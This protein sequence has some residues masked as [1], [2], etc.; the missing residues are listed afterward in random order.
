MR[1]SDFRFWILRIGHTIFNIQFAAIVKTR[2]LRPP[3]SGQIEIHHHLCVTGLQETCKSHALPEQADRVLDLLAP[4]C[5]CEQ[6]V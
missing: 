3:I 2:G 1:L 6:P 5:H 4:N